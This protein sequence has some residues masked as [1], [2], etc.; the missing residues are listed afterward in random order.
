MRE[1]EKGGVTVQQLLLG[2]VSEQCLHQ[3]TERQSLHALRHTPGERDRLIRALLPTT[4]VVMH[5]LGGVRPP[6][7]PLPVPPRA[8][9]AAV[10]RRDRWRPKEKGSID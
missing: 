5:S 7:L 9:A 10:K 6:S 3:H 8:A 2:E 1:V 4:N